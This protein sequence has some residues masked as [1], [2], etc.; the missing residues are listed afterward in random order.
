MGVTVGKAVVNGDAIGVAVVD[1]DAQQLPEQY[2]GI[3]AG[4]ERVTAT[5]TVAGADQ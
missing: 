2:T 4:P 5:P 3:L 1:I